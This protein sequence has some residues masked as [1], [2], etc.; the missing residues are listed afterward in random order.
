MVL[1]IFL[2]TF[3]DACSACEATDLRLHRSVLLEWLQGRYK[4]KNIEYYIQLQH[5]AIGALET[6]RRQLLNANVFDECIFTDN[7]V[8]GNRAMTTAGSVERGVDAD[9]EE[10]IRRSS[11]NLLAAGDNKMEDAEL[12]EAIRLSLINQ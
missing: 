3:C 10:A 7:P 4:D 6:F 8:A 11:V 5:H 2:A 9:L 1:V 12:A